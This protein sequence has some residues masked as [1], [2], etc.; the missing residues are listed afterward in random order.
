MQGRLELSNLLRT[1]KELEMVL[2]FFYLYEAPYFCNFLYLCISINQAVIALDILIG[3]LYT[4]H[5]AVNILYI[6]TM[7][8]VSSAKVDIFH[9]PE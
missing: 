2:I 9:E 7:Y 8:W 1:P 3:I 6:F 5:R 4:R